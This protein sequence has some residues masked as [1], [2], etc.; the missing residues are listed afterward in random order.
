MHASTASVVQP[1]LLSRG[2]NLAEPAPQPEDAG[3]EDL[4][5]LAEALGGGEAVDRVAQGVD[6]RDGLRFW[7]LGESDRSSAGC[8]D[9]PFGVPVER[10]R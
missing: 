2:R 1:N 8:A 4:G 7:S 6:R 5:D 3:G 10:S 9:V